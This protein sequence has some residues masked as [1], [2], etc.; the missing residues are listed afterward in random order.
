MIFFIFTREERLAYIEL[1]EDAAEGPHVN[2]C[3]VGDTKDD[4][5]SSVVS[6]LNIKESSGA[7]L[8]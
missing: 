4:L 6:A 8:A 7:I 5:G 3:R 1:V 2:G